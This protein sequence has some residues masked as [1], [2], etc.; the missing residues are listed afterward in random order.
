MIKHNSFYMTL[1]TSIYHQTSPDKKK[2]KREMY[3]DDDEKTEKLSSEKVQR[4]KAEKRE[5]YLRAKISR[6]MKEFGEEEFGGGGWGA[7][8]HLP[9]LFSGSVYLVKAV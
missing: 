2:F 5:D 7:L 8:N 3:M 4:R 1:N 9:L 6:S